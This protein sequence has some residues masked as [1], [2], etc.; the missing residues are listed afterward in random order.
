[1]NKTVS[2]RNPTCVMDEGS[3]YLNS[4]CAAAADADD[5]IK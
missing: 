1:M 5:D 4:K 2:S 3:A